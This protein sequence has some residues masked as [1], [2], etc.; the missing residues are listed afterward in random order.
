MK[1]LFLVVLSLVMLLAI[2]PVGNVLAYVE[3][4]NVKVDGKLVEFDQNPIIDENNRTLVPI[5]FISE[6]MGAEVSW[7]GETQTVTII[8]DEL[9]IL[10]NIGVEVVDVANGKT[11]EAKK[12]WLDTNPILLNGRTLVPVR[13]ISETFG[14]FVDWDNATRTVIIETNPGYKQNPISAKFTVEEIEAKIKLLAEEMG[15]AYNVKDNSNS[16][17]DEWVSLDI[18][19]PYVTDNGFKTAI[20]I[21]DMDFIRGKVV[22]TSMVINPEWDYDKDT[23]GYENIKLA[24]RVLKTLEITFDEEDFIN[25]VYEFAWYDP[26][27]ETN[28]KKANYG[29]Y[30]FEYSPSYG[31]EVDVHLTKN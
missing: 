24:A 12:V 29:E 5:R 16:L 30:V 26:M 8:K 13:F 11:L 9:T 20:S 21:I 1:K 7:E 6:E 23:L 27:S 22:D 4:V 14:A 31:D 3:N 18:F 15:Y 28:F 2:L 19:Y 10:L 25:T 17:G